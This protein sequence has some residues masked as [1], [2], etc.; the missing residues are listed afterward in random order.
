MRGGWSQKLAVFLLH[1]SRHPVVSF[2]ITNI[3]PSKLQMIGHKM[4]DQMW[5]NS[6]WQLTS[7]SRYLLHTLFLFM[8]LCGWNPYLEVES[9]QNLRIKFFLDRIFSPERIYLKYEIRDPT[10]LCFIGSNTNQCLFKNFAY[11]FFKLFLN[12][13]QIYFGWIISFLLMSLEKQALLCK[14]IHFNVFLLA[15]P[16]PHSSC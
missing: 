4:A 12:V 1:T 10:F 5:Q 6:C 2:G 15:W 3:E 14:W 8:Y 9:M 13:K 16:Q 7:L 11:V